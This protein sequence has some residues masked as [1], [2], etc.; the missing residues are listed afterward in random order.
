M[1]ANPMMSVCAPGLHL[2][3]LMGKY[4]PWKVALATSWKRVVKLTST[5]STCPRSYS[6]SSQSPLS[7]L[8]GV[9]L[10]SLQYAPGW[11]MTEDDLLALARVLQSAALLTQEQKL[12]AWILNVGRNNAFYS[13]WRQLMTRYYGLMSVN[14]LGN[15]VP[16]KKPGLEKLRAAQ[17]AGIALVKSAVPKTL[18]EYK[19]MS[20]QLVRALRDLN[21]PGLSKAGNY[22]I[23]WVVRSH[24]LA[25]MRA[26]G[27]ERC[28]NTDDMSV[29]DFSGMFPDVVHWVDK[30]S[31]QLGGVSTVEALFDGLSYTH[32]PEVFSMF[33][34]VFGEAAALATSVEFLT[35]HYQA[36]RALRKTMSEV[37]GVLP[38]PAV[39]LAEFDT[40]R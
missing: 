39:L 4:G 26:W 31:K 2:L 23:P 12:D 16:I 24:A 40:S 6:K 15:L 36:L 28:E 25:E 27:I 17:D 29:K 32:P 18:C 1:K 33:C 19:A 21:P 22:T 5:T 34:C 8:S 9:S 7:L 3:S 11:Q 14:A 30:F 13:G 38:V 10:R 20:C 35:T 37:S